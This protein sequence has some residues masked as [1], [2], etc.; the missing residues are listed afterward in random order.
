MS[1]SLREWKLFWVS[2]SRGKEG[3]GGR[4]SYLFWGEREID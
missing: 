4:K 1:L 2:E 3:F